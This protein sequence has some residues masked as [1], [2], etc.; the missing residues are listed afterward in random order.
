MKNK[1]LYEMTYEEAA[2]AFRETDTA[3]IS[4]G[5]I[6]QHGPACALGLD[7]ACSWEVT[8]RVARLVDCVCAPP[9]PIGF[10]RQWMSYAGTLMLRRSTFEAMVEDVCKSLLWH[11]T[12]RIVIING[13][14]R[15]TAILNDLALRLKYE[16]G[17]LVVHIDWWKLGNVLIK[18]IG[19]ENPPEE[20]PM[21]HGSELETS[22]LWAVSPDY[23]RPDKLLKEQMSFP[24]FQGTEQILAAPRETPISIKF[25]SFGSY[26]PGIG[27]DGTQHTRSGI[28]GSSLRATREKGERAFRLIPERIAEFVRELQKVPID[29]VKRPSPSFY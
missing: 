4:T 23:V 25:P 28:V 6:E 21:G 26:Q 27:L 19:L 15:N 29:E 5:S 10:A 17:A 14:G 22:A 16:T 1:Y 13:H 3:L 11:G 7:T 20:L 8:Q 24:I 2:V 9:L 18:E 12:K